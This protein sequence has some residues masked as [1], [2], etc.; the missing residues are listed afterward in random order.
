VDLFEPIKLTKKYIKKVSKKDTK[1]GKYNREVDNS[2]NGM[3]DYLTAANIRN[4]VKHLLFLAI[5]FNNCFELYCNHNFSELTVS[6]PFISNILSLKSSAQI[7][8]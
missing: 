5:R 7:H 3:H 2:L 8:L 4:K 1:A 6:T